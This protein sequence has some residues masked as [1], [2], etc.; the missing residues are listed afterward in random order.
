MINTVCIYCASSPNVQPIY[1]QMAYALGEA[2]AKENIS[3]VYGAGAKGPMGYLAKGVTDNCGKI[4]GII[5]EFMD[6]MGWSNQ[7]ITELKITD[8]IH[9]RKETMI[10]LSQAIIA[11]PGGNGTLEE[12]LEAITWR[13]LEL[14]SSPIIIQNI[15]NYYT[16]LI[17][18]LNKGLSEM[19][20]PQTEHPLWIE[21]TTIENTIKL[22]K[23][24]N[25]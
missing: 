18:M 16:P 25:Q 14:T 7:T 1:N 13:Q 15:N 6:K 5:P 11:L 4:T 20:I 17:T 8:T 9:T 23:E 19:F 22:L 21:S 12:L 24:Y 3:V 2:L 10:K